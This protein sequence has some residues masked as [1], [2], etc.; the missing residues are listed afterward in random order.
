MRAVLQDAVKHAWA[1]RYD[2]CTFPLQRA[3]DAIWKGQTVEAAL[4]EA[5]ESAMRGRPGR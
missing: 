5:Q 1:F 4:A 3:I 2:E